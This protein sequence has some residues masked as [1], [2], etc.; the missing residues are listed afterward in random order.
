M[1]PA[2][3]IGWML[4]ASACAAG[5]GPDTGDAHTDLGS[6]TDG[7]AGD[8]PL[9]GLS[10]QPRDPVLLPGD[11]QPL[12]VRAYYEDTTHAIVTDD[13]QISVADTRVVRLE[14]TGLVAQGAGTTDVVATLDDLAARIRVT[15][16]GD[17]IPPDRVDLRPP[18]PTLA[19]GDTLLLS[20][21]ATWNDGTSGPING[22]AWT[23]DDPGV[24]S[25]GSR[26]E[27]EAVSAGTTTVTASCRGTSATTTVTVAED[28]GGG[29]CDLGI[30][31]VLALGDAGDIVW[32]IEVENLGQ[33]ACPVRPLEAWTTHPAQGSAADRVII[34]P[35]LPG[36]WDILVLV[37][38]GVG[39]GTYQTTVRLG[40]PA[41]STPANDT[42][43]PVEAVVSPDR[44]DLA[45]GALLAIE[46]TDAGL[47]EV[48]IDVDNLG[49]AP[50]TGFWLDVFVDSSPVGA[51]DAGEDFIQVGTLAAGAT[52]S[53]ETSLPGITAGQTVLAVADT[54]G[55]VDEVDEGNNTAEDTVF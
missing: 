36:E 44:P 35:F 49:Q 23:V 30:L 17:D 41:D 43:G 6:D 34:D 10:I 11:T 9:L 14:G 19:P 27:L 54:C 39:P 15:V 52:H 37:A 38:S 31:D 51:C 29:A 20:A 33:A 26:G 25:L 55:D 48:L 22:C 40:S 3:A 42:E 7:P 18:D 46:D 12:T 32:L 4:A 47:T 5:P 45:I 1:R 2:H 28:A 21:L 24:A 16:R 8:A 53:W 50:A 13:V